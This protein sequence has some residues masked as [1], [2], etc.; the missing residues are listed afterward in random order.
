MIAT[1]LSVKGQRFVIVVRRAGIRVE[2]MNRIEKLKL[3]R[4][5]D[6]PHRSSRATS[7][8]KSQIR[9]SDLPPSC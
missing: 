6:S 2:T 3:T 9:L 1:K 4:S 5:N 7:P 8:T